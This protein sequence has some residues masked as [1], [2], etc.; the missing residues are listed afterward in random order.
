[1]FIVLVSLDMSTLASIFKLFVL[2]LFF[3]ALLFGAHYF[4]K[5]FAK[6]SINPGKNSNIQ[7][8]ESKQIVPGKSIV[9][10]R[11]G[12]K[13][14]SFVLAKEQASMLTEL[15][16]D[17]LTIEEKREVQNISFKEVLQ[18]FK[19]EDGRNDNQK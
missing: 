6:N 19:K 13:I 5:W 7:I 1:M 17:D 11:I 15:Q 3:I 9:I 10:A 18:R 2:L 8:I 14:V 12:K 4:T 16:E